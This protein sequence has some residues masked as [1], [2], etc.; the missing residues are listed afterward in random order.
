MPKKEKEYY[1]LEEAVAAFE[2]MTNIRIQKKPAE[3]NGLWPNQ[4]NIL[5]I[6]VGEY[7]LEYKV[8]IKLTI[9]NTI[10]GI[11]TSKIINERTGWLLVTRYIDREMAR[12][13]IAAGIQFIDATGNAYINRPPVYINIQGN[14]YYGYKITNAQTQAD[15]QNI[16]PVKPEGLAFGRAGIRIIYAFL[17]NKNLENAP[18]REIAQKTGV[19]LGTVGWV[20]HDLAREGYL[21]RKK[22][23]K[24]RLV[25]NEQLLKRWVEA[26]AEKLRPKQ[27]I[28]RY[29]TGNPD[30]LI[31]ANLT[32]FNALW[33]G[34]VAAGRLTK[35]LNPEIIT[36]YARKPLNNLMIQFQLRQRPNGEIELREPFWIHT[37]EWDIRD[38]V[39]PILIYAD[40]LAT[41][42]IRNIE[43]ARILYDEYIDK[44]IEEH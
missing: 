38:I 23:H 35:Y 34:E 26:Y 11:I 19:A 9:T 41:G 24:R 12:N 33:G 39:H 31:H 22:D 42:N 29:T 6:G 27:L 10:F 1:L 20:L 14:R 16:A 7:A 36:I 44:L 5:I 30:A 18:Y 4:E 25:R 17:C 32:Q 13:L 21:N 28:G 3:T 40:L 2:K 37:D 8:E 15:Y 43:T